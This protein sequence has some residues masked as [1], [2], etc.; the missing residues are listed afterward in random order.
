M[1]KI[2]SVFAVSFLITVG[3]KADEGMWLLT[4]IEKMNINSMAELGCK[5]SAEDIYSINHS[6]IKDA[7]VM[8]GGGCTGEMISSEGLL[9]TNHHCGY[10]SIQ[11][12]STSEHNYLEDGYWAKNKSE[13]IPVPGLTVTLLQYMKDVTDEIAKVCKNNEEI[14]EKAVAEA[15][16]RIAK[17]A[18]A[19]MPGCKAMVRNFYNNNVYYLIV[20]KVYRD[21]RFVGAPPASVGKFG[22]EA[23]N[24]EWPRH[25]GDFSMFR[26][27]AGKDNEPADYSVDNIPYVPV[28]ALKVSLKGVDDGDFSFI[29]G[30]PG[31][32]QRFQT[33]S[34]LQSM[35][36][37]NNVRVAARTCRQDVM[38]DGMEADPAVRL[39]YSNK[40]ASS[41]NGW[42]KWQGEDLSFK[43]LNIIEREE[44]KEADFTAWVSANKKRIEKYGNALNEINDAVAASAQAKKDLALL[45][46]TLNNIGPLS[47]YSSFS[48][49]TMKSRSPKGFPERPLQQ[50]LQQNTDEITQEAIDEAINDAAAS[51][52][53][54][55][56]KLERRMAVA[57]LD[58]YRQ[59][60]RKELFPDLG[61]DFASMDF[62]KYVDDMFDESAFT[63]AE[64]IQTLKGKTMESI[65]EDSVAKF[66]KVVEDMMK[67][68]TAQVYASQKQ[69]QKG[70]KAFGAGLMEWKAGQ[71]SYPD[72]NMTMR[73]T[74]GNV[75]SYSPKDGILY[76]HYTTI[77]GVMEKE[78]P[79]DYEFIVP[80]KLKEL[81]KAKD[82]GQYADA[83][84]TVHVCFLTNNDITG[85]N[86]GS[87]VLNADGALIGLAF[88][89][90]WESM[91]SD[92]MFEPE[93]QRCICVDIRYVLFLVDKLGGA[94]YLIDEMDIV[95]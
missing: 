55:N 5:L 32:T 41:A 9:V 21:V 7:I 24:W 47:I 52:K 81:W 44:Q 54:Y 39:Q 85:G 16:D 8:F 34:Q 79:D 73:L 77:D 28:Q 40:Y 4:L 6:S 86:S 63:S 22:G 31:S 91:S 45:R 69:L 76:K 82:Y 84:G 66:Q 49:A 35:I 27:Y 60:A 95:R 11:K 50:A 29:M 89:G 12:L 94:G 38:V 80:A 74:Y 67:S 65:N 43:K 62:Q 1:K 13:E 23:D 10:G 92:V 14:D 15:S 59:N 51:F 30:Y 3:A 57:I 46:E 53:D 26:V 25:T 70:S 2:L 56:D 78:N 90:N 83:D 42:K 75:K 19:Q 87:P 37:V 36:D 72:A 93:L 71:V 17:E 48:R 68:L 88:D 18:E 61:F 20:N 64:K 58:F 33:A